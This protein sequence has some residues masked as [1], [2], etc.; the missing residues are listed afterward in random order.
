MIQTITNSLKQLPKEVLNVVVYNLMV[1]GCISYHEL[2]DMHIK[3][4]KRME[5]AETEAYIRLQAKVVKLYCDKKKNRSQNIK[6]IIQLLFDEGRI[7]TTQE[8]IDKF[9]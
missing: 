1:D 2:M 9:T 7:N 5:K 8:R 6:D 3:N 4:L